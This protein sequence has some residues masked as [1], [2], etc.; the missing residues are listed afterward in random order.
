MRKALAPTETSHLKAL[1]DEFTKRASL[2]GK[3]GAVSKTH[4][5]VKDALKARKGMAY[6][7][8]QFVSGLEIGKGSKLW[9]YWIG[10]KGSARYMG[11]PTPWTTL[12]AELE[13]EGV[14]PGQSAGLATN[15]MK[16][17]PAGR[18]LFDAH[19][20]KNLGK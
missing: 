6:D 4:Q 17:T 1:D 2:L 15:I 7:A 13:K 9:L 11:S 8:E 12:R 14:P 18:A 5:A 19:H 3:P 16:A 10:P 20:G